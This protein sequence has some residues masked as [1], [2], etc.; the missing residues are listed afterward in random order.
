M[1]TLLY[2]LCFL[3]CFLQ[4]NNTGW[5]TERA[6]GPQKN[7]HQIPPKSSPSRQVD[8]EKQEG[9]LAT[10]QPWISRK[11]SV[12]MEWNVCDYYLFGFLFN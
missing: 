12:K 9:Q 3:E 5:V 1:G 8:K 6:S 4:I 7:M 10:G 11:M 2:L